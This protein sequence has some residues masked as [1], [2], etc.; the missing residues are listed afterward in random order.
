MSGDTPTVEG[1]E[2][3][4]ISGGITPRDLFAAMAM[5]ALIG[6]MSEGDDKM[7]NCID[8]AYRYADGMM[9]LRAPD[10]EE[11]A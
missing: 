4:L 6:G 1:M 7:K 3:L 9:A 5:H 2:T 10:E 8:T 11:A